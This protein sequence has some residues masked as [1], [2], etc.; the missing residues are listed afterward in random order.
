MT[1]DELNKIIASDEDYRI[2]KTVSMGDMDKFQEAICAFA[3]DM[4]GSRQKGYLLIGVKDNGTIAGL[5]VTDAL[6]KRISGI[7]LTGT[8]FHCR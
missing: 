5:Q 2:E 6:M 8:Y 4:P 3:N 1:I 7:R